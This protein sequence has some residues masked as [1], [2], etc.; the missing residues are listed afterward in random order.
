MAGVH[1]TQASPSTIAYLNCELSW[2]KD[3]LGSRELN[4]ALRHHV[5]PKV[6]LKEA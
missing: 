2:L 5:L 6:L 3:V 1:S 4:V